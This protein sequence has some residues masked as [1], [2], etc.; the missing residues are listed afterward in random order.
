MKYEDPMKSN[1]SI[2]IDFIPTEQ[3]VKKVIFPF[4]RFPTFDDTPNLV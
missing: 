4:G 3:T 1:A 2:V